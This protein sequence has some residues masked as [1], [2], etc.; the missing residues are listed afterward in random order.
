MNS[1]LSVVA[2]NIHVS[3][4]ADAFILKV[5]CKMAVFRNRVHLYL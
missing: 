1:V 5:T 2:L 3:K 4:V